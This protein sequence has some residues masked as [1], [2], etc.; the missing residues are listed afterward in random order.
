M[1]VVTYEHA[2]AGNLLFEK[3]R[4]IQNQTKNTCVNLGR[5]VGQR[6]VVFASF[7]F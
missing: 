5:T 6:D 4:L 1:F 2:R 7:M 3:Q